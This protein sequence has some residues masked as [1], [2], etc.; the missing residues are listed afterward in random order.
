MNRKLTRELSNLISDFY[1][2]ID[3]N[4]IFFNHNT[5]ARIFK[6][7]DSLS[8][9][10]RSNVVYQYACGECS[11]VYIG[12][13]SRHLRTRIAEHRGISSRTGNLL[14][15]RPNSNIYRHFIDTGHEIIPSN[16][17]ILFSPDNYLLKLS[18]SILIRQ[19]SPSLNDHNSSVPL[20]IV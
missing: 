8:S 9:S 14:Q 10:V 12:E 7:K 15:T 19:H 11:A 18:E 5:I 2:Q 3:L 4:L 1:P 6:Y 20:S 17:K 13:T 16:F